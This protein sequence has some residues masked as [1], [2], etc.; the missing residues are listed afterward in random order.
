LEAF[1]GHAYVVNVPAGSGNIT[2]QV[3]KYTMQTACTVQQPLMSMHF[4]LHTSA[5]RCYI[6]ASCLLKRVPVLAGVMFGLPRWGLPQAIPS[7][8]YVQVLTDLQIPHD[9]ERLLIR[10]SN[11]DE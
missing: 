1:I 4:L 5:S 11:S 7:A 6:V 9:V 10:T 2:E 8:M 3:I